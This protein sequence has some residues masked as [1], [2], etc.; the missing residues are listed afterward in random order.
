VQQAQIGIFSCDSRFF[1]SRPPKRDKKAGGPVMMNEHL[2]QTL[3]RRYDASAGTLHVR[4]VVDEGPGQ[5]SSIEV[6]S[7]LQAMETARD[8][9]VD[10]IG[11]NLE[12][13][14]P[15]IKAQDYT[16]LA[17]K[18][19]SKKQKVSGKATKEF[20][21]RAGIAKNDMDRKVLDIIRFLKKGHNCRLSIRANGFN[22]RQDPVGV[23]NMIQNLMEQV[24]DVG[25]CERGAQI[26]EEGN[27]ASFLLRPNSKRSE[28]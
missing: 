16:K 18:A 14:P 13:D 25:M 17:Y 1:S 27:R 2:I 5:A 9:D 12:Q 4:L 24:G 23:T 7:L 26:N 20:T 6:V 10:L 11:I 28:S 21:F 19:V 15:V 22:M 8:L 3:M